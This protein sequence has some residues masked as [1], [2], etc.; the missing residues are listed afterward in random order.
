MKVQP[1]ETPGMKGSCG[2]VKSWHR[3][4]KEI[5]VE[6]AVSL[7]FLFFLLSYYLLK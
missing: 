7:S 3:R 1:Q 5:V 4:P 2:K 6:D